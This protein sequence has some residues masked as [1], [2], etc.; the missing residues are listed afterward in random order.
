MTAAK[1]AATQASQGGAPDAAILAAAQNAECEAMQ[2][3]LAAITAERDAL[4]LAAENAKIGKTSAVILDAEEKVVV[5]YEDVAE[6]KL[7]ELVLDAGV[8]TIRIIVYT[9][10]GEEAAHYDLPYVSVGVAQEETA[11]PASE[12]T[13]E[14]AAE[15]E[16]EKAPEEAVEETPSEEAPVEEAPV[17][18]APV[19][20]APAEGEEATDEEAEGK[21]A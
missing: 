15:T 8:Y 13:A 18:E 4:Q 20:E 2:E 7:D 21:A 14:K 16:E 12:E 17:E 10:A 3:S 5:E 9:A 19:E 1:A 11:E 6:L